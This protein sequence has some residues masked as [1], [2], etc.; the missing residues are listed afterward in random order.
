VKAGENINPRGIEAKAGSVVLEA[1]SGS[2][3]LKYRCWP[4]WDARR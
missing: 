4:P 1:A 3:L 2:V